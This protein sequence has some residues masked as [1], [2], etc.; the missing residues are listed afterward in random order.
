MKRNSILRCLLV[1]SLLV[2]SVMVRA[3]NV[4]YL[5][6]TVDGKP[7]VIVL[8]EHPV[9]TYT[10]NYLHIETAEKTVDV[11]V[12]KVSGA[13]FS[14]TSDIKAVAGKTVEWGDGLFVFS[15]LPVQS[16]VSIYTPDGKQ[17]LATTADDSGRA[18][19]STTNLPAGVY[20]V[21]S[22]T[23]TIKVTIK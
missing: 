3:A 7:V 20:I 13:T 1:L 6:L 16:K 5:T 8:A 12:S 18:I 4:E 9:I 10:N 11:P 14:E 22:A 17:Q 21:K 19:I 2:A 15:Q 23:Q